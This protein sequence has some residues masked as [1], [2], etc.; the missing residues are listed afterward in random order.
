MTIA[1]SMDHVIK[2]YGWRIHEAT[3]LVLDEEY[4]LWIAMVTTTRRHETV[5][6]QMTFPILVSED[7]VFAELDKSNLRALGKWCLKQ[8]TEA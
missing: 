1:D 2:K 8:E 4:C 7:E 3:V 5:N 6:G